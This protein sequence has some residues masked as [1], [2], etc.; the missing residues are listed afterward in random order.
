MR[1]FILSGLCLALMLA[2]WITGHDMRDPAWIACQAGCWVI[3]PRMN[4]KPLE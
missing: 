1:V 3:F 2:G 4:L